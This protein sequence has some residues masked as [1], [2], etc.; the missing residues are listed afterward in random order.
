MIIVT[1]RPKGFFFLYIKYN[2]WV[3]ELFV[4]C[5]IY[6]LKHLENISCNYRVVDNL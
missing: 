5:G 2:V 6:A 1:C 3:Y 4:V